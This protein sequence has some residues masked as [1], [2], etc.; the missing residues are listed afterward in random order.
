MPEWVRAGLA[1]LFAGSALLIGV[2]IGFYSR[3]PQRVIAAVMA[4]GADAGGARETLWN[5]RQE[6]AATAT[7]LT[8]CPPGIDAPITT[9]SGIPSRSAPTAI[10][11]PVSSS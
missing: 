2:V 8:R 5:V 1:G 7:A 10:A 11:I 9:D 4:F 3:V 6:T